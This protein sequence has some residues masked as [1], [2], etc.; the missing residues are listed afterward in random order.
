MKAKPTVTPAA[1]R[2]RRAST[3]SEAPLPKVVAFS[4]FL[5]LAIAL[6]ARSLLAELWSIFVTDLI[7]P[8]G[9]KLSAGLQVRYIAHLLAA[10]GI[11]LATLWI[12][13]TR[14]RWQFTWLEAGALLMVLAALISIPFA[15]DKRLAIYTAIDTV[16]PLLAAAVLYQL[17]SYSAV[18]RRA[19]LA[20]LLAM[21]AANCWKA[22]VQ[23]Y[24]EQEQVWQNYQQNK[25]AHLARMGLSPQDPDAMIYEAR[26]MARQPMGYF[27]HPNVLA[28]FAALG[29][30]G[31]L[32]A[33]TGWDWRGVRRA[34]TPEEAGGRSRKILITAV[35]LLAVLAA[36][37]FAVM[38]WVGSAG[39]WAGLLAAAAA[40]PAAWWLRNQP[41]RLAIIL[42]GTLLVLQAALVI[43]ALRASS[44]YPKLAAQGGKVKSLAVR[45]NYW[46]GA[47]RLFAE[48]PLTGVGPGQ[49]PQHYLTIKPI[50]ATEGVVFPHNWLLNIAADWGTL[51]V[52]GLLLA[53]GGVGW[54][55]ARTLSLP[56]QT[57]SGSTPAA[58]LPAGLVVLGCWLLAI[59]DLSPGT[60]AGS[61]LVPLGISLVLAAA[62]SLSTLGGQLGQVVL[63]AGLVA[64]FVHGTVETAPSIPGAAGPF[65]AMAALAMTWKGP[66]PEAD[67][68]PV[69]PAQRRLTRASLIFVS[70]SAV[71]VLA[72]AVQPMRAVSLM[73]QAQKALAA[74]QPEQTVQLFRA[75][76][77]I[78][79]LDPLP[80]SAAA[81]LQQRLIP[82]RPANELHYLR[83]A[84][85][86]YQGAVQRDPVNYIR[87]RNLAIARMYLACRVDDLRGV[88]EALR[89]MEHSL[90]LYPN[91]PEGWLELAR[92]AA[93]T[94]ASGIE[95]PGLLKIAIAATDKAL[96]LDEGWPAED[97]RKFNSDKR[98]ELQR[99]RQ[100]LVHRLRAA[101]TRPAATLPARPP[102]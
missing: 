22:S 75:A 83:E 48:N 61:V 80:L 51:G 71:A 96:T 62:A 58:L 76:A 31:T 28:S 98:S 24:S 81:L 82:Y 74:G 13:L 90:R 101:A 41:K 10:G 54:T 63:L 30:V 25:A 93:V 5:L 20:A 37:H 40:V 97:A 72:L 29:L 88:D 66:Q 17:L 78:D 77:Q 69:L 89:T 59:S 47:L 27:Q 86:F 18:W 12:A 45:L 39:A 11:G 52:A 1:I 35:I 14:R 100:D 8:T 23:R 21:T 53:L 73:C 32:V 60:S 67:P 4:S 68:E 46:E 57:D 65:W 85:E 49:F 79:R 33:L 44:L 36:W 3:P 9:G 43:L 56:P 42:A 34:A 15:S 16:L 92:M 6:C 26:L 2:S 91:N 84:V 7:D 95:Q 55:I 70:A 94:N 50:Y 19:L 99:M 102:A 87:W 38:A 64:F